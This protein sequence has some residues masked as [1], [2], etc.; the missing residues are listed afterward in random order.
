MVSVRVRSRAGS[1]SCF[2]AVVLAAERGEEGAVLAWLEDGGRV[3]AMY[4]TGR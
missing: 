3:D 1:L 4:E 2:D